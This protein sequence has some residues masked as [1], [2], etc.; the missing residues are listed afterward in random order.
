MDVFAV[1]HTHSHSKDRLLSKTLNLP[2]LSQTIKGIAG[3]RWTYSSLKESG[4]LGLQGV[5]GLAIRGRIKLT[6][7][8]TQACHRRIPSEGL[9]ARVTGNRLRT[10][11]A[12][13]C[14]TVYS[15]LANEGYSCK[16]PV[17]LSRALQTVL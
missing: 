11:N 10:G 1:R 9:H 6:Y 7:G 14:P 16:L 3:K 12:T 5:E 2:F 15:A 4:G 17:E 8:D 13:S